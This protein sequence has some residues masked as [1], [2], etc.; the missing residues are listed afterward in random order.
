MVQETVVVTR[1]SG[2]YVTASIEARHN[3]AGAGVAAQQKTSLAAEGGQLGPQPPSD[4]DDEPDDIAA[5]IAWSSTAGSP[6]SIDL[7]CTTW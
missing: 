7:G 4:S 6:T 1:P 2:S 3:I 5:E